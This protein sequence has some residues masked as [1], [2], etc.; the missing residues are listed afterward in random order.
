MIAIDFEQAWLRVRGELAAYLMERIR[1]S[2]D[3]PE[4]I[5]ADALNKGISRLRTEERY[6]EKHDK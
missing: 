6:A 2:G 3:A 1:K 4:A 5:L